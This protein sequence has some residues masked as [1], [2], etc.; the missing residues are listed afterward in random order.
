M[1]VSIDKVSF[2][3]TMFQ[4]FLLL[5]STNKGDTLTTIYSPNVDGVVFHPPRK[6]AFIIS[7]STLSLE[8]PLALPVKFIGIT[9]LGNLPHSNLR[10]KIELFTDRIISQLMQ[11]KLVKSFS[12]P[13]LFAD[14]IASVVGGFDRV[15]QRFSLLFSWLQFNL[16]NQFH[17]SGLEHII[18]HSQE[19]VKSG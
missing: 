15:K 16:G 9:Y 8:N 12:L 13:C 10:R 7:N 14:E 5:W 17:L 2:A 1:C 19:F 11:I 6:D 3:K 4:K 18:T